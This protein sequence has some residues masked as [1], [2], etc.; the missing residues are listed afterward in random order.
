M[1]TQL[2]TFH[3]VESPSLKTLNKVM[4]LWNKYSY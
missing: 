1:T 4:I 2:T 3:N